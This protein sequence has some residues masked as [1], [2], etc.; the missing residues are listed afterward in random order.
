MAPFREKYLGYDELTRVVQTWAREHPSIVRL[1]SL[2]V[3][4]EGRDLWLLPL[5]P[6]PDRTR[7]AA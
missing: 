7:P 4:P 3:T 5:G 6:D 2:A 1:E